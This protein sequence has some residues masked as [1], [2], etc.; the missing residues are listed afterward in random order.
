MESQLTSALKETMFY[1]SILVL[2]IGILL[3]AIPG[4]FI[5]K[6]KNIDSWIDTDKYF[7]FLNQARATEKQFYKYSKALSLIIF[8]LSAY[9][10]YTL[11]L[12]IELEYFAK[13][14]QFQFIPV[15]AS[16]W[17]AEAFIYILIVFNVI[18]LFL[19]II[20]FLR[21]SALRELEQLANTWIK[22]DSSLRVLDNSIDVT[23]TTMSPVKLRIL[24]MFVV[25]SCAY[26]LVVLY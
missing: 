3:I 24:G 21:P 25:I 23:N 18:A 7:N 19:S 8:I 14:V 15:E 10:L 5:E 16:M 4:F 12:N 9:I 2:A 1:L 13:L 20:L 22:S 17:L 6:S 26:I 11:T